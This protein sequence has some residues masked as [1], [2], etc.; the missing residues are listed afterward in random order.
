MR[1]GLKCLKQTFVLIC[2][3]RL[4][5][6]VHFPSKW[7]SH[8]N[9][10]TRFLESFDN[11]ETFF[12]EKKLFEGSLKRCSFVRFSSKNAFFRKLWS[13]FSTHYQIINL[14][15]LSSREWR[16]ANFKI[17]WT[18]QRLARLHQIPW[19]R[20]SRRRFMIGWFESPN[21]VIGYQPDKVAINVSENFILSLKA[22][23]K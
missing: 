17:I 22:L 20:G 2:Q 21:T 5:Y 23:W 16:W 10:G 19:Y 7:F 4:I 1:K 8:F 3:F 12:V 13:R 6:S 11:F 9:V 18:T 14:I 15:Y